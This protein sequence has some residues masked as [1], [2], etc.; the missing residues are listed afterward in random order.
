MPEPDE[1]EARL[2]QAAE[3]LG[4]RPLP[5][6][7]RERL[8]TGAAVRRQRLAWPLR[9]QAPLAL[10]TAAALTGVLVAG[11]ALRSHSSSSTQT[12]D[13]SSGWHRTLQVRLSG[14]PYGGLGADARSAW[15]TTRSATRLWRVDAGGGSMLVASPDATLPGGGLPG[16]RSCVLVTPEGIWIT[17]D[18]RILVINAS[19][20]QMVHELPIA[21]GP[22]HGLIAD[23]DSIWAASGSGAVF[24]IDRATMQVRA[25]VPVTSSAAPT[26]NGNYDP[27]SVAATDGMIWAAGNDTLSVAGIDPTHNRVTTSFELPHSENDMVAAGGSLW[28]ASAT[29][30]VVDR[31]DPLTGG[32]MASISLPDAGSLAVTQGAVWALSTTTGNLVRIDTSTNTVTDRF[33]A[34]VPGFAVA[35]DGEDVWLASGQEPFVSRFNPG[36]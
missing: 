35:A 2:R 3:A 4:D 11:L 31:I 15:I 34:G 19:S 32:L 6:G 25:T 8:L 16:R 24:R 36:G 30:G 10:G 22:D 28:I 29:A 33:A 20:G 17:T 1:F 14:G 18:N 5:E 7:L 13:A 9:H 23:G 21:A 26:G 12:T 27:D